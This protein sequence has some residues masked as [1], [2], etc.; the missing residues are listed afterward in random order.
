[1]PGAAGQSR[2]PPAPAAAASGEGRGSPRGGWGAQR[3]WEGAW[4]G[5]IL[6]PQWQYLPQLPAGISGSGQ[7]SRKKNKPRV[8]S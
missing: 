3:S 8:P 2:F 5:R 1:M 7:I 6:P 4:M